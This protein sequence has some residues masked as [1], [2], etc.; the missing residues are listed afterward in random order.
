MEIIVNPY[1]DPGRGLDWDEQTPRIINEMNLY[2]SEKNEAFNFSLEETNHGTAADW[3]TITITI[4]GAIGALFV[5]PE[6]HKRIRESCEEW[7]R[8]GD[9]MAS[10]LSWIASK[11]PVAAYPKE[12]LFFDLLEWFEVE[13][14]VD[15]NDLELIS[16][17]DEFPIPDKRYGTSIEK[18]FFFT[19]KH[20]NTVHQ[21]AV[22]NNREII[23]KHTY[24][25]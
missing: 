2:L 6:A 14:G 15:A 10:L 16:L 13:L 25:I 20:K 12:L 7:K 11:Y 8:I 22:K 18:A 9:E 17:D 5:I 24:E 19:L 3:P 23:W 4:T 1:E 21:I